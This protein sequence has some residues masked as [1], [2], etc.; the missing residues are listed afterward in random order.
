M[1]TLTGSTAQTLAGTVDPPTLPAALAGAVV[2]FGVL[3]AVWLQC[4]PV[5]NCAAELSYAACVEEPW[6]RQVL[7][8]LGI[9]SVMWLISL[10]TIP[11]SGTSDPSIVDR[12]WSILPCN[13]AE[14]KPGTTARPRRC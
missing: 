8:T 1:T 9:C 11:T 2:Q 4:T 12:L 14:P 13:A 6:S 3:A 5:G 7:L 10:R